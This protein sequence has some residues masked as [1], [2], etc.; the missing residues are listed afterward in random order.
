MTCK[1]FTIVFYVTNNDINQ[2]YIDLILEIIFHRF[3]L[4]RLKCDV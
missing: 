2:Y 1:D 3:E 4:L